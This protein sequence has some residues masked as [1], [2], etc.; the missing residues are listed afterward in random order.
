M[1]PGVGG[2]GRNAP[3]VEERGGNAPGVRER[4]LV[5]L[6]YFVDVLLPNDKLTHPLPIFATSNFG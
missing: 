1:S 4:G 2:R 5:I 6:L 3:G